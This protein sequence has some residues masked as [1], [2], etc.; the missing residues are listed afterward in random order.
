MQLLL[1]PLF[2]G[3]FAYVFLGEKLSSMIAPGALIVLTGIVMIL[4]QT[5]KAMKFVDT[6]PTPRTSKK[7]LRPVS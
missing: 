2:A 5:I 6:K 4:R 1:I 3:I 7:F